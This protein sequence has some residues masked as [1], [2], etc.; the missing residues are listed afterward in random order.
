MHRCWS[1]CGG[2]GRSSGVKHLTGTQGSGGP[3]AQGGRDH[4][5]HASGVL[6]EASRQMC[7]HQTC[8]GSRKKKKIKAH[9]RFFIHT[10]HT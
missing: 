3:L 6:R 5:G 4:S 8:L 10:F 2:G 9:L 7:N 1:L